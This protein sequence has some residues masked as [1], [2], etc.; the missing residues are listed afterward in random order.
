MSAELPGPERK[1]KTICVKTVI[2]LYFLFLPTFVSLLVFNYFP[3]YGIIIAFQDYSIYKGM[4]GGSN[5]VGFNHFIYFLS[6]DKFWS[7]MKNTLIINFYD[8]IFGFTAPIVFALLANEIYSKVFKRVMQTISYLPHFLSWIVVA[9][10]FY[11]VLS[12][13]S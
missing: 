3:M 10:I 13:T 7:V 5:W 4:F 12:P 8:L 11:Q 2:S 9:G 1:R 6:D